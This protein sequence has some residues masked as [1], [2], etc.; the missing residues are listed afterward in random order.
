MRAV[1]VPG[2]QDIYVETLENQLKQSLR[3]VKP[4]PDFVDHL[5]T[6]LRTPATTILEHRENAAVGLLLVAF[7]LLSGFVLIF[8]LRQFRP[9]PADPS[10]T[11]A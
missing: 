6:R 10:Y 8:V 5:H 2:P 7:S 11:Q 9:M 1:R 3:P 4:N